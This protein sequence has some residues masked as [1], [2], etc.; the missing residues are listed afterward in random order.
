MSFLGSTSGLSGPVCAIDGVGR[1]DHH[2]PMKFPFHPCLLVTLAAL[3]SPLSLL[4]AAPEGVQTSDSGIRHSFLI[5]G[6]LTAI[7]GE[8]NE[9]VW[10]TPGP[11]RDGTVLPNGNILYSTGKEGREFQ[12]DG[13]LVWSYTLAPENKELGTVWRLENGNTLTVERGVR[14]RLLEISSE[15]KIVV[16]VPLQPETDN[17]HM[18]TRM[19]RKL[20]NGNYLVPHLLAFKVKEY[21]PDGKIVAEISTRQPELTAPPADNWPFTAIRLSNGR[22]LVNLTHGNKIAEF[23]ASGKPVWVVDNAD[24]G[25]RFADPCGGQRLPN[26]NTVVCSYGQK[27]PEKAKI[28]EINAEKKVVWEYVNPKVS[29][30]HEIHVLTTNGKP[31]EGVPLK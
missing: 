3:F 20:P 7:I 15:G 5:T 28:F 10:Q 11:S 19:A 26:G 14:P 21:S 12:R 9:I 16:E 13:K 1:E 27:A 4:P 24:V 30:I 8:D 18:Q 2:G 22:T 6:H 31:V 17:A 29:G 23:D 25:G